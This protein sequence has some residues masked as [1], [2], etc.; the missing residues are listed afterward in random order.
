P[1]PARRHGMGRFRARGMGPRTR[2][3]A[4]ATGWFR[5]LPDGVPR[6]GRTGTPGQ[7]HEY[8]GYRFAAGSAGVGH[9][10]RKRGRMT[11]GRG[12]V[13]DGLAG[14]GACGGFSG[15]GNDAGG[16]TYERR[17]DRAYPRVRE[18][19]YRRERGLNLP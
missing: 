6:R 18:M 11:S 4:G 16:V 19:A 5:R 10:A 15:W 17:V 9:H 13:Y 14:V 7:R 3:L 1:V 8:A 12:R 2:R